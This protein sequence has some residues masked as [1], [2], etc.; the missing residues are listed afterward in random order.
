MNVDLYVRALRFAS[1]AH[2]AQRLPDGDHPYLVH[3][4]SVA[5]EVIAALRAEPGRDE[6]LAVACALLHDVVE[7][8]EVPAAAIAQAFGDR[9]A[10]GVVAL[11]KR[12]DIPKAER[13]DDSLRRIREQPP[14]VWMVKL[15]DR[16]V[17]LTPPAPTKWTREKRLA[18][19]EEGERIH[20]A[21][22]GASAHLA[23]RLRARVEG[24]PTG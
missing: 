15:A 24:Y 1:A 9:V 8:T 12:D 21:L 4:A 19:R 3:L 11:S 14:E 22:S 10:A 13:L 17:N 23:A 20:A 2:D 18:Y 6:D 16:I 7:D 5:A